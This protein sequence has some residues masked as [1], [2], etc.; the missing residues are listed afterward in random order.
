MKWASGDQTAQAG[1]SPE[2][3]AAALRACALLDGGVPATRVW[4]VL[5][6]EPGASKRLARIS[7]QLDAGINEE[8]ALA[9]GGGAQ[10]QVLAAAWRLAQLSGAPVSHA[11]RRIAEGLNELDRLRQRRQVLLTGPRATIRLVAVLPVVAM[12]CG[13][14]LGF[15]PI[16]VLLTPIG[17]MI[18]CLGG[19]L[20]LIGV[21][22]AATLA[23]QLADAEW[24]AGL[25]CELS[26][27]ALSG[28]SAPQLAIRSVADQIDHIAALGHGVG[29]AGDQPLDSEP[30]TFVRRG[31]LGD[32]RGNSKEN[33][34]LSL[35]ALCQAGP[36][37][38]AIQL[39]AAHGTPAG[40]MLLAAATAE[41]SRVLHSLEQ[42]AERL[43]VR[44]LLPIA[45]CVLPSFIVLGVL[46]VL[47]AVLGSLDPLG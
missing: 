19:G 33:A 24:V 11:L 17:A 23:R 5:G 15:D 18:A 46:P 2:A 12:L 31:I 16:G 8:V 7:A 22:W 26:W 9:T 25:E 30:H 28:G 39:A 34:W 36:T 4:R 1:T 29:E 40:P 6:K 43:A 14:L 44:M 3:A 35:A 20:L 27:I 45:L 47:L 37:Q 21:R 10:W 32:R 41:R 13:V 42:E 38:Q